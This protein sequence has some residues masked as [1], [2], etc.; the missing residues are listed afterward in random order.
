MENFNRIVSF[1]LGLVVV[2]VFLAAIS[3]RLNLSNRLKGLVGQAKIT[4]IPTVDIKQYLSPA[5]AEKTTSD[6]GGGTAYQSTS[7]MPTTIPATGAPNFL[8]PLV[9]SSFSFGIYLKKKSGKN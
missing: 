2:I 3:G 5:P 4:P 7:K 9:F 6:Q 1:V 8:L